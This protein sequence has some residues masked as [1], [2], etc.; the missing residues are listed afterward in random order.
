MLKTKHERRGVTL[1][2]LL[3]VVVILGIVGSIAI[4]RFGR[5]A[6]ANFGSRAEARAISL[7]LLHAKRAAILT[8]D[9]HYVLFDGATATNYSL[10]RVTGSGDVLV[11]G[12]HALSDDV[13]ITVSATRMEFTFEGQALGGYTIAVA[14][15]S[16]T[17]Q[18]Q[19]TLINGSVQVAEL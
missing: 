15:D 8:G 6:F 12:P 4:S 9:N 7:A 19:V 17:W 1:L 2:E 11:D 14:G 16:S 3:A 18:L 13:T 5:T 10:F